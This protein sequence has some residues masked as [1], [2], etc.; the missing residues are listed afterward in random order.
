M[1]APSLPAPGSC[2]G[3][4][5]EGPFP[6]QLSFEFRQSRE[7]REDQLSAGGRRVDAGPLAG[8]HPD[9]DVPVVEVLHQVDEMA[10]I[11][12]EAIEPPDDDHV[13]LPR[14]L[15]EGGEPRA[16][17]TL[18]SRCPDA[19]SSDRVVADAGLAQ[20]IPLQAEALGT[21][22]LRYPRVADQHWRLQND[23]FCDT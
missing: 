6:D 18:S 13:S 2:R 21:V 16:V 15:E 22:R 17:L 20:S 9:P 7:E 1:R 3:Q 19:W 8:E 4:S 5:S 23:R 11:A 10:E 12:T 14:R